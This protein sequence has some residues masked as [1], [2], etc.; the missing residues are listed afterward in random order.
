MA[1]M[2]GVRPPLMEKGEVALQVAPNGGE[3]VVRPQIDLFVFDGA[4]KTFDE[5]VVTPAAAP[6]HADLYPVRAEHIQKRR[7]GEFARPDLC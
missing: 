7:A 6:V 4:P 3:G 1:R 5:H 2:C